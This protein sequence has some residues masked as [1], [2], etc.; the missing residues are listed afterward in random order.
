MPW[1][2]TI[3]MAICSNEDARSGEGEATPFDD[4][5]KY[6]IN[7]I[8]K[9]SEVYLNVCVFTSSV[10]H[11]MTATIEGNTI[12]SSSSKRKLLANERPYPK[13]G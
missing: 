11:R 4:S 5:D 9:I 3:Y 2:S 1:D 8:T 6:T 7:G 12:A 10:G 13:N